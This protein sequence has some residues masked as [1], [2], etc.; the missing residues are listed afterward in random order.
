MDTTTLARTLDYVLSLLGDGKQ[1]EAT[2]VLTGLTVLLSYD[3]TTGK[4]FSL[5]VAKPNSTLVN[6]SEETGSFHRP[7]KFHTP[8]SSPHPEQDA[9][10]NPN[11]EALVRVRKA[12]KS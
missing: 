12:G 10:A 11:M 2:A 7:P 5:P 9:E 1:A 3:T 8:L 6:A 4:A